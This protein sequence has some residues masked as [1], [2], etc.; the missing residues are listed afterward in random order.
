M[1]NRSKH[2]INRL[3]WAA[4]LT[5]VQ[6]INSKRPEG[7][8]I[9]AQAEAD[10]TRWV[11]CFEE[12]RNPA[13]AWL[14][15]HLANKWQLPV[16]AII[17]AEIERFS[18]G[19]A[20]LAVQA[21]ADNK[22]AISPRIVGELWAPPEKSAKDATRRGARLGERL[23]VWNSDLEIAEHVHELK[24]RMS[25][26]KAIETVADEMSM[27]FENVKRIYRN[28][29]KYLDARDEH[30]KADRLATDAE[31]WLL[32]ETARSENRGCLKTPALGPN[33]VKRMSDERKWL[34]SGQYKHAD[35]AYLPSDAPTGDN[36][37]GRAA[38]KKRVARTP[39][40]RPRAK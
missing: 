7:N 34:L 22:A 8:L 26:N 16:P 9:L 29:R 40:S 24:Q 30:A 6:K 12:T 31:I 5:W 32:N 35:P 20:D 3:H 18:E 27:S 33:D 38:T 19:I 15:W 2:K 28:R 17:G 4:P 36:V 23:H 13:A 39:S 14:C 11:A 1:A 25:Q 10:L 21:L 37:P